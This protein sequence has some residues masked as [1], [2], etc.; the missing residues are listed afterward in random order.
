MLFLVSCLF[1]LI[2]I[3]FS[4]LGECFLT[5]NPYNGNY[6]CFPSEGGH[7]EF[8]PRNSLEIGLLEF[9]KEKF[10]Q[11]NRVSVERVISGSGLANIY[12][13]LAKINPKDIDPEIHSKIESAGDLKVIFLYFQF[14]YWYQI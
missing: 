6:S 9:L 2:F 13:Y 12:E 7:A 4:G 3:N 10:Q 8:S 11:A 5:P 14:F 1:D